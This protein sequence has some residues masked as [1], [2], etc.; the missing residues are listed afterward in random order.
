MLADFFGRLSNGLVAVMEVECRSR[1]DARC[2]F[3]AG[4][5]DTLSTLYDRMAQGTSYAEALGV[6]SSS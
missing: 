3:L 2:R 6:S 4:S 5:P 1:S